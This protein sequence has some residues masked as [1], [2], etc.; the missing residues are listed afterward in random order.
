MSHSGYLLGYDIGSSSVKASLLDA[1]SGQCVAS[2]F[3]PEKEMSI[4]APRPGW[5]EQD[6]EAWWQELVA[7]THK[8]H[9]QFSFHTN[10][11]IAIGISYQM[12]GLV[13]VDR[14]GEVLRPAIIWCDSRAVKIGQQAFDALGK[15]YCLDHYLN[16]PGNF[17]AS[18]LKWVQENEPEVY[19]KIYKIMLPGDYIAYRLT[20]RMATTLS[21]LSEGIFW[22]FSEQTL[23]GALLAYYGF[24]C[25]IFPEIVPSFGEQGL[26]SS[27]AARALNLPKNIPVT[28]RAGDQPNNAYS[29]GV[30]EPGELA[31]TAGTSGVVYGVTDHI[32][33]DPLSR[34]NT[35][36][37]VNNS[38]VRQRNG[39]LLC[40]NGT[41]ISY[42]WMKKNM[43]YASYGQ[44]NELAEKSRPGANSLLFFPFGNGA[45]RI[46]QNRNPGAR[47][48]G[49]DF[50]IHGKEHVA[51]AVQ[52]G[53]AYALRYGLEIMENMQIPLNIFRAGNANM[54]LSKV[55]RQVFS[56]VTGAVV[57][58]YETDGAQGA[59]RAAGVGAKFYADYAESYHGL[60]KIMQIIPDMAAT[61]D[62]RSLYQRWKE[63][64][65]Q[66]IDG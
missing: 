29:L 50:N 31:A 62:Y 42:S 4:Q 17:T 34:V 52:E 22:D 51:R 25:D 27:A 19:G 63:D 11:V 28:Y 49:L 64:L 60:K 24:S 30:L 2:A 10:T 53:V 36:V 16:S 45:E 59:A 46:L 26:L 33:P 21:G 41:G 5:G 32:Q 57:E 6:P 23:A 55:F 56:D 18:K 1:E 61:E 39:V 20:D 40:I 3:S 7:A 66:F 14:K 58:I 65:N 35:F 48:Q 47:L 12:H 15:N 13:C 54:F 9:T 37:H 43:G 8:L 44:M 38:K